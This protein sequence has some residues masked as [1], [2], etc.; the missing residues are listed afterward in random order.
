MSSSINATSAAPAAVQPPLRRQRGFRIAALII[1]VGIVVGMIA[2]P[3]VV[4]FMKL[5]PNG[6]EVNHTLRS[7]DARVLNLPAFFSGQAGED[8][9]LEGQADLPRTTT[10]SAT[11]KFMETNVDSFMTLYVD[12]TRVTQIS[13]HQRLNRDSAY[14]VAEPVSSLTITIPGLATGVEVRPHTQE[15]LQLF[16]PFAAERRSYS[17]SDTLAPNAV[18]LDYVD[19]TEVNGVR[20]YEFYAEIPPTDL[21]AAMED[22]TGA[23]PAEEIDGMSGISSARRAQEIVGLNPFA[24]EMFD[25]YTNAPAENFFS[26]EEMERFGYAEGQ[27]ITMSPFYT[28]SR[29]YFVEPKTG[30][31]LDEFHRVD[32]FLADDEAQANVMAAEGLH[33]PVRTIFEASFV[34][35]EETKQRHFDEAEPKITQL[36]ALTV[37]SWIANVAT[38]AALAAIVVMIVRRRKQRS[39]AMLA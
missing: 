32:I 20:T 7:D 9:F 4:F 5:I 33:N 29:T 14:P 8:L 31:V 28:A 25:G 34:M 23:A 3:L 16:F 17:Y 10:T 12:G 15:G 2:P 36:R 13:D 27:R 38:V 22:A 6:M 1:L 21:L 35:D 30:I 24:T 19:P 26:P 18:P 37:V 39:R 11:D